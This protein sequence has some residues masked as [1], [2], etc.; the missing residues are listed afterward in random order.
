MPQVFTYE[1]AA[2]VRPAPS[3]WVT[4]GMLFL[5]P[6]RQVTLPQA[7]VKTPQDGSGP[8]SW[9][10]VGGQGQRSPGP[11]LAPLSLVRDASQALKCVKTIMSFS[12]EH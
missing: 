8:H 9:A 5:S 6:P 11:D 12:K 4:P 7:M 3:L 10:G 2:P 1:A